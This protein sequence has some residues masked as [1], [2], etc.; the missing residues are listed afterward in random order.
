MKAKIVP[1]EY[2]TDGPATVIFRKRRNG[3]IL[4]LFP[5]MVSERGYCQSYMHFGQ[6]GAADYNICIALT[7]PATPEEYAELKAELEQVCGY[8]LTVA[9][10]RHYRALPIW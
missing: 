6:A 8:Q 2:E 4:A 10:R 1:N 7:K 9:K 3:D 5:Y